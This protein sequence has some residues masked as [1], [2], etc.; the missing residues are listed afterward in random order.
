MHVRL[1]KTSN[2]LNHRGRRQCAKNP[3][4]TFEARK[5]ATDAQIDLRAALFPS[6]R[7]CP[8]GSST[9]TLHLRTCIGGSPISVHSN[10]RVFPE[11]FDS[12]IMRTFTFLAMGLGMKCG[13]MA[14]AAP[15]NPHVVTAQDLPLPV[16]HSTPQPIRATALVNGS[17]SDPILGM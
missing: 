2:Y 10:A 13:A 11:V 5:Q 4:S 14:L 3:L 9:N 16:S 17:A 1:P 7:I 6:M 8:A 15:Q 12:M